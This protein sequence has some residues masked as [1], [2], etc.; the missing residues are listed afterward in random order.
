MPSKDIS[1]KNIHNGHRQ[2]MRAK[3]KSYGSDIFE[4][5]ELLEMLLYYVIP[6][7]DTNPIAKRLLHTFGSL[8]GVFTASVEEL[9]QVEGVGARVAEYIHTVSNA[10]LVIKCDQGAAV[11][12]FSDYGKAA[13]YFTTCLKDEK[14]YKVLMLMLDNSMS[15][16]ELRV[17][18]DKDFSQGL[19]DVRPYVTSALDTK[20][21]VVMIA[22]N[23]PYGPSIPGESDRSATSLIEGALADIG[24]VLC[25]HFLVC[26]EVCIGMVH[27]K[28]ANLFSIPGLESFTNGREQRGSCVSTHTLKTFAEIL[29]VE[30]DKN[31]VMFV[32]D[33]IRPVAEEK[34]SEYAYEMLLNCHSF[35]RALSMSLEELSRITDQRVALYLKLLARISSRRATS[36]LVFGHMYTRR[37][38]SEYFKALFVGEDVEKLYVMSVSRDR[39]IL[40]CELVSTGTVNSTSVTRRRVAEAAL[41]VDA[42]SV[43]LAHNHPRGNATPSSADTEFTSSLKNVL[44]T[45]GIKLR[46]HYIV[47]GEEHY[48]IDVNMEM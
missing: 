22:H 16:I 3:F 32:A 14:N 25:E 34:A 39:R 13:E 41:S 6:L 40:A 31:D 44:N 24:V 4:T 7:S 30:P 20:A 43:I 28:Y 23:H 42:H 11:S 48:I 27:R 21:S 45:A 36:R 15:P 18:G 26:G 47:A 37:E 38:L 19:V 5:Y 2:R 29:R 12:Q 9:M 46:G 1:D 10:N 8:D 33:L 35:G 17:V